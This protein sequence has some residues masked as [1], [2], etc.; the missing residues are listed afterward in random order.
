MNKNTSWENVASWYD[1]LLSDK[2]TYQEKVLL[3]NLLRIV[4]DIRGK[5]V[6]DVACGQGYFTRALFTAG[7][8]VS[9]VD[10]SK[11]LIAFARKK[12]PKGI[13]YFESNAD[14]LIFFSPETVDV[15]TCI[16][17]IQNIENL[18]GVLKEIA[19]I[20]KKG[21]VC[22]LIINHPAFRIPK[23]S[24][25]AYDEQKKIQYRRIE[26][27]LSQQK[28]K[29]DMTPGTHDI[30]KKEYTVSF[31]RSL[32]DYFK[33]FAKAGFAVIRLEEWIS[34]R[35]SEKGPRQKAEDKARKE[36]PLFMALEL[37]KQ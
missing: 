11:S 5:N 26:S 8:Q 34:H 23:E 21:G 36:F 18:A 35:V 9:G 3:P 17:A 28:N 30:K 16:L 14:R 6:V 15:A 25:W 29:I 4:G 27:Y 10:A 7:A 32:Q 12:G 2:D 22:Y 33:A 19:K 1:E 24:A 31:H 20:L 13:T 37:K